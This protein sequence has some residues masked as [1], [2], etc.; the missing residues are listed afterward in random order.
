MADGEVRI[1]S[2]LD[3]SNVDKGLKE[4]QSKINDIWKAINSSARPVKDYNNSISSIGFNSLK[5]AAGLGSLTL[6]AKKTVD[7]INDCTAAY[8]TQLAAE[9]KLEQA[10]KTNPMLNREGIESLKRYASE[11]QEVSIYGDEQIIDQ[12]AQLVASGRNTT[13]IMDIMAASINYAAGTNQDLNTAVRQLSATYTGELGELGKIN[14]ALR[15]LTEEQLRSGEAVKLINEQYDGMAES[16]AKSVGQSQQ[17]KNAWGDVAEKLGAAFKPFQDAFDTLSELTANKLNEGLDFTKTEGSGSYNDIAEIT[18]QDAAVLQSVAMLNN[19][20]DKFSA[21]VI[22][23]LTEDQLQRAKA[24]L[25]MASEKKK[26][27]LEQIRESAEKKFED[28]YAKNSRASEGTQEKKYSY[29]QNQSYEEIKSFENVIRQKGINPDWLD[30]GMVANIEKEIEKRRELTQ[31]REKEKAAQQEAQDK[32]D[33]AKQI[34]EENN[35]ALEKSISLLKTKA[36]LENKEVDPRDMYQAYF[37]S[38]VDLVTTDPKLVSTN[39]SA[40]KARL[41]ELKEWAVAAQEAA[42]AEEK[43]KTAQ[44]KQAEAVEYADKLGVDKNYGP[45]GAY[46]DKVKHLEETRQ[47]IEAINNDEIADAERKKELLENIDKEYLQARKEMVAGVAAEV[48][49]YVSQTNEVIQNAAEMALETENNR[50]QAELATL[51]I[52]YRQGELG[53]EEYQEK[54]AAA[55]KKGAKIQYQIEMAQWAGNILTA[56]ANTAV[57]VTQAIA[58]GGIAGIITGALVGAA[59]AVQ[60][61]TIMAAKPIPHFAAGGYVGGM[62]GACLG[63]DNT[64]IAARGGELIMNAAQQRSLWEMLNN[65]NMAANGGVNLIVNNSASNIVSTNAH[66]DRN[67]IELMID[68][69]V[70]EGLKKGRFNDGLN[71][72]NNSMSGT[73]YGI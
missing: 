70:N 42:D 68:A 65:G 8:K 39:N 59:G 36:Q 11:L 64:L 53:E 18:K 73:F 67:R 69:R 49:E 37:N 55:K 6:A 22:D 9:T 20:R 47:Q 25:E 57:G 32:D 51:E 28:W 71:A 54:V 62:T 66:I 43:L 27:T 3:N 17:A 41:E 46:I 52:K 7:I 26:K 10:M 21:Q 29:F 48:N 30:N 14:A 50:M 38:Y 45:I 40:A 12:M 56:T 23:S 44:Q 4:L 33:K 34:I 31:A 60:L 13:E 24:I 15:G 2:K 72:A 19:S 1:E 58:Q 61:A 16:I 5:T 35:K 63:A